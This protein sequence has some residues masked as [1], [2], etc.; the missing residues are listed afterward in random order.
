MRRTLVLNLLIAALAA[1]LFIPGLGVVRLFDWD[2]INFAESAREML[3]TGDWFN[4][5]INFESFWEKPPL[6]IWMQ[7]LSMKV[8][9]VN[10]FAARF[11]NA[12][13][14]IVTLLLLFNIG[15]RHS[16]ER[17]GIMWTLMYGISFL[18]FFYF[19]SGII[20]P[21]FNLFIF[22]G[23][24][25]FAMY[26]EPSEK[27]H[28]MR[29]AALSALWMGL[30][31][32]TKGPVAFLI[33]GLTVLAWLALHRFRMDFRW[34]DV[35]VYFAVLLLAG[36][37]WFIALALTG[38]SEVIGDFIRY[39]VRLFETKDAGHGGFL[40]YHFVILLVGVFPASVF[41]LSTFSFGNAG[42]VAD[43]LGIGSGTEDPADEILRDMSSGASVQEHADGDYL[44]G[45]VSS[46]CMYP[47]I[48]S[49]GVSTTEDE[50]RVSADG[51]S[52]N[53]S[54]VGETLPKY[55]GANL[56]S[57]MMVSFWVVLILFTIVRTKIVHYSSFCYF[58]LTYLGAWA[59]CRM[60]DTEMKFH[61]WQRAL[62]ISFSA[63]FG[64]T[65]TALTLFDR[66]KDK[67][68]PYVQD[69][70]AVSCMEASSEW[71]GFE[72]LVGL[73]LI[74]ATVAFCIMFA[75]TRKARSFAVLAAGNLIFAMTAILCAVPEVEK[76][77]QASAVDF[78]IERQGE[79]CYV[80][81]AYFKSYAQ[82]FY[83]AREERNRCDDFDYLCGGPIDKPCYFVV[84]DVPKY[85]ERLR[86]DA[87]EA[88]FLY[89]R[90]GFLFFVREGSLE[91][92]QQDQGENQ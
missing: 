45:G 49:S 4:V 29:N 67:I 92:P 42:S 66:F 10:E 13:I 90:S 41:A 54:P 9:G 89:R 1:L 33:F 80:Q 60:M 24:Y 87:P 91:Q 39:Q 76:Y 2:E 77:S 88:K 40:L 59:A 20:D 47:G 81:P 21:W 50:G 18:P 83:T 3:V 64:L 26:T 30:A 84:K 38:H 71:K 34:K 8:F 7:A 65:L 56:K 27:V 75:R 25:R 36:G 85:I 61:R 44:Q 15:R 74:A 51:M 17:F 55:K 16:G 86:N 72:P 57:W 78:Y 69:P 12:L 58:P 68:I 43:G 28:R 5:R 11:P 32:L 48:L 22:L 14:G 52:L 35:G 37:S 82:Y 19:K 79:D 63:F 31:V 53:F 70:F 6:F 23:I 73:L 62:L 46:D